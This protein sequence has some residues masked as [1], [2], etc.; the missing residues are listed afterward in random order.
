MGTLNLL[1][2]GLNATWRDGSIDAGL[3]WEI[4][5]QHYRTVLTLCSLDLGSKLFSYCLSYYML[6]Q[7]MSASTWTRAPRVASLDPRVQFGWTFTPC[8]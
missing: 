8:C 2:G 7:R 6:N 1:Y 3:W 5:A 4:T